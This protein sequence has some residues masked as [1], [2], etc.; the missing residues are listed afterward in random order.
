M[1]AGK[2]DRPIVIQQPAEAQT[3]DGQDIQTWSTYHSCY[4]Q[5][6]PLLGNERFR[7]AG[8]HAVEAGKFVFRYKTGIL[9]T[10]R[11]SFDSKF[12]KIVA[13]SEITRRRATELTVE[14]WQ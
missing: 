13:V 9:P 12:Y 2:F 7:A 6:T 10:M 11:V 3:A 8:T 5:W 4:A 14:L 1:R